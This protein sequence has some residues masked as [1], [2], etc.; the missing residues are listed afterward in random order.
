MGMEP[1]PMGNGSLL[2]CTIDIKP[3]FQLNPQSLLAKMYSGNRMLE[4]P[5]FQHQQNVDDANYF[6]YVHRWRGYNSMWVRSFRLYSDN[7]MEEDPISHQPN[8]DDA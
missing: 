6:Q 4:D 8:V 7:R 3:R 2:F 5:M 1:Q